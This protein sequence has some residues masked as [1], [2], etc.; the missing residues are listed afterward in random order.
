MEQTRSL[1]PA[2][3]AHAANNTAFVVLATLGLASGLPVTANLVALVA[4]TAC[5]AGAIV[6]LRG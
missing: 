1:V 4:G 2:I 6:A 5:C 3:V